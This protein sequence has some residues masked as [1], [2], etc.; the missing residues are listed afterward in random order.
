MYQY[1]LNPQIGSDNMRFL[2]GIKNDGERAAAEQALI[3]GKSPDTV[4][5]A[6]RGGHQ[7]FSSEPP[8]EEEQRTRLEKEKRRLERTIASLTKR[9]S[10]VEEKLE[11]L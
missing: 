8:T 10:D 7:A 9:L 6:V 4:K 11:M 3:K 5:V 2:A 1:N